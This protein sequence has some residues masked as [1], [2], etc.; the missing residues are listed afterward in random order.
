MKL[1]LT[2]LFIFITFNSFADGDSWNIGE[3]SGQ[4]DQVMGK[5]ISYD[6]MKEGIVAS[7]A[8]LHPE[9]YGDNRRISILFKTW[10]GVDAEECKDE[11]LSKTKS[12]GMRLRKIG[13]KWIKLE[14]TCMAAPRRDQPEYIDKISLYQTQRCCHVSFLFSLRIYFN[15]DE[16]PQRQLLELII[17]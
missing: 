11:P 1:F 4:P 16:N 6:P 13:G 15:C 9:M 5:R 17:V 2:T 8:I 7:W 14:A 10:N 3:N 12:L